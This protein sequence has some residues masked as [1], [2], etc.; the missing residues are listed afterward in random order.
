[1][2][3]EY[4]ASQSSEVFWDTVYMI[5]KSMQ[6]VYIL[7]GIKVAYKAEKSLLIGHFV[8]YLYIRHIYLHQHITCIINGI[9]I[10]LV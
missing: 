1:M 4:I 7:H 2:Y 9:Y 6:L 3:I 5:Y 8:D 10:N